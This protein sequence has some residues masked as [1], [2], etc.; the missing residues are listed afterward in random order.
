L[1]PQYF[2]SI[3]CKKLQSHTRTPLKTQPCIQSNRVPNVWGAQQAT[4]PLDVACSAMEHKPTVLRLKRKRGEMAPDT[5]LVEAHNEA[6]KAKRPNLADVTASLSALSTVAADFAVQVADPSSAAT[7]RSFL[8][9]KVPFSESATKKDVVHHLQAIFGHKIV[10]RSVDEEGMLTADQRVA[11]LGAM[12]ATAHA[13]GKRQTAAWK[14]RTMG[15]VVGAEAEDE[16][17]LRSFVRVYDAV[18]PA[19]VAGADNFA[20]GELRG[21]RFVRRRAGIR[22]ILSREYRATFVPVAAIQP[23]RVFKPL[24]RI[25]DEAIWTGFAHADFGPI[26]RAIGQGGDV[27]FQRRKSD[28]STAL[29]AA[30]MHGDMK[31]ALMLLRNNAIVRICD[32]SGK[33]AVA[34]AREQDHTRL[35]QLLEDVLHDEEE[36]YARYW[37]V[38]FTDRSGRT[39]ARD[40]DSDLPSTVRDDTDDYDLYML[41]SKAEVGAAGASML[42]M[43]GD[44]RLANDIAAFSRAQDRDADSDGSA[45]ESDW[46]FDGLGQSESEADEEDSNAED[47][48]RDDYPEDAEENDGEDDE[49]PGYNQS[50]DD[51]SDGDEH[52]RVQAYIPPEHN[53]GATYYVSPLAPYLS[54][55]AVHKQVG[56]ASIYTTI[57]H[58]GLQPG[59]SPDDECADDDVPGLGYVVPGR[60]QGLDAADTGDAE[61]RAE[62][63]DLLE[64][65]KRWMEQQDKSS[66]Q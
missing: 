23:H 46:L 55:D 18:A 12:R 51:A 4:I 27:N 64:Q 29:M 47:D 34:F 40:M 45:S 63:L 60:A 30:A 10:K 52:T 5:V 25:M 56:R 62:F 35:A 39:P 54:A 17:Y 14:H 21:V 1:L 26:Y 58:P 15:G 65:R 66:K 59:K 3:F 16:E 31:L 6:P 28:L 33:S 57:Q 50:S 7:A 9:R 53:H 32:V 22:D 36:E 38:A 44:E 37:G 49:I 24:E 48:E 43:Q 8:F 13:R 42:R 41:D 11:A 20:V 2:A 19:N 61:E